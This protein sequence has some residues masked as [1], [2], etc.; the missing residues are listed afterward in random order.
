MKDIV[1]VDNAA[2]SFGYQIDNGI[3]IISWHDDK[4]DRE[5]YNLIDY[6]KVLIQVDDIREINR[7]TFHLRTF[8]E[9]YL[10]E[11]M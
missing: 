8:Y 9:D 6:L 11:F 1:I 2:Y 4:Y 5:L 7:R 3:P 10:R